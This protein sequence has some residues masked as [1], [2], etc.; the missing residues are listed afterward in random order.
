MNEIVKVLTIISTI[1]IPLSFIASVYGMNFN[2]AH[3]WNMPELNWRFGYFFALGLMGLTALTMV[4]Y[5]WRKG[6][7]HSTPAMKRPRDDDT[8]T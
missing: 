5:F 3:G 4:V 2:T 8:P 6:W 1:F 7:L